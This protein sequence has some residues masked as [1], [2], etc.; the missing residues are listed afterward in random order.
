[1]EACQPL[2]K[3]FRRSREPEQE[4]RIMSTQESVRYA[5]NRVICSPENR[6]NEGDLAERVSGLGCAHRLAGNRRRR[7]AGRACPLADA[8]G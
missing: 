1:M 4:V 3:R 8:W 7:T 5:P 6:W 2:V